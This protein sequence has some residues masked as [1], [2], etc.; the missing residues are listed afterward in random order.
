M[1]SSFID[2]QSVALSSLKNVQEPLVTMSS[3][4]LVRSVNI[5]NVSELNIRIF[6]AHLR[7]D[8]F[9]YLV[10]NLLITSNSSLNLLSSGG[11]DV[12][13]NEGDQLFCFSADWDQVFDCYLTL[14]SIRGLEN[15]PTYF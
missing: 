2:Y 14:S 10:H 9:V 4:T 8:V 11:L 12:L 13:M 1:S 5:C 6:L 15:K 3:V 7:D